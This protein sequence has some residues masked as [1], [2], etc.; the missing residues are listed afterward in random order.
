MLV[1]KKRVDARIGHRRR[2]SKTQRTCGSTNVTQKCAPQVELSGSNDGEGVVEGRGLCSGLPFT[3]T[4]GTT[5]AERAEAPL[6]IA[7]VGLVVADGSGG[8]TAVVVGFDE[9]G[10]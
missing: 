8:A 4:C 6:G 5:I 1:L 10:V 9:D 7:S 2:K 3:F